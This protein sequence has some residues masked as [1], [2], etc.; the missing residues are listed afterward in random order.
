[1]DATGEF[2][3]RVAASFSAT[4]G[5]AW[6][7]WERVLEAARSCMSDGMRVLD[8][9]CGN[10]RFER[11]LAERAGAADVLA[12]DGCEALA[13]D[14][15]AGVRWR[16]LDIASALLEEGALAASL[17]EEGFDLAVCFAFAHH[18]PLAEQRARLVAELA[19]CLRPGGCA[20]LSFWQFADD[21]R[22]LAKA[23]EASSRGRLALGLSA[24]ALGENDYLLGWA[25]ERDAFRFCHHF[26]EDEID[27]L[28]SAAPFADEIARFSADGREG[29]LNRYVVLAKRAG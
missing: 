5:G 17:G 27:A 15:P 10:L 28:V 11:F 2:Y 4:R 24:D 3:A 1:M 7:G 8:L 13:T 23:R 6:P 14:L 26:T 25:D 9:A 19:S 16:E 21:E 18:L 22:L 20:A 29:S 12:V